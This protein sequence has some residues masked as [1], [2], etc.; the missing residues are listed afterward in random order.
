MNVQ[1]KIRTIGIAC[2]I[3]GC[4]PKGAHTGDDRQ[5]EYDEPETIDAVAAELK[6]LGYDPH[7][8]AQDERFLE[9]LQHEPP[10]MMFNIAEGL[11]ATRGRESQVP[12]LLESMN[13]PYTG[14]DPIALGI[15][16]D[17]YLTRQF[18]HSAYVPVPEMYLV[19]RPGEIS[20]LK[21]IFKKTRHWIVKPRWEGS[22]KGVF[23]KSLVTDYVSL[24]AQVAFVLETYNQPAVVEEFME[25]MEITAA[26]YGNSEPKLLGMMQ[27]S[28]RAAGSEPFIYSLEVKRDWE[29]QVEY[30]GQETIPALVRS[31]VESLAV[32]AFS[33]LELRD[34]ARVDFR[35][36]RE[37]VPRVI[38][39]NPL[40]G[41]SPRYSDL[42]ILYRLRGGKYPD[43]IRIILTEALKRYG[44]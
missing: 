40:P 3:K 39:I 27:I 32:K 24:K 33:A 31:R 35:L 21:G 11:G 4:C 1:T 28:P 26:V 25:K 15:T 16:L 5:E 44:Y 12:C 36:D 38:D 9:R 20:M 29:K 19:R 34:I 17:K 18:L 13:I 14:S 2:N 23:R 41:L 22:S 30:R 43:L 42:P 37:L 8:F 6:G 10:D 7:V